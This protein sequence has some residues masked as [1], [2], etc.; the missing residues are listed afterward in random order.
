MKGVPMALHK[1]SRDHTQAHS[2]LLQC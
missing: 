1:S 2:L